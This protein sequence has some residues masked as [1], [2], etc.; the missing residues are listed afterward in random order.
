MTE[1]EYAKEII[2]AIGGILTMFEEYHIFVPEAPRASHNDHTDLLVILTKSK[3][4]FNIE[5][6]RGKIKE[7]RIQVERT[8]R[9]TG[10]RTYG[11][12]PEL[13][14]PREHLYNFDYEIDIDKFV[15]NITCYGRHGQVDV[16]PWYQSAISRLYW[17]GYQDR[18]CQSN[19]FPAVLES[20]GA[21]NADRLSLYQLFRKAC[22]QI[23]AE[24]RMIVGFDIIYPVLGYG[25]YTESVAKKHYRDAVKIFKER[26]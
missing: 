9:K 23:F 1:N 26:K 8:E 24:Q 13:K 18:W 19:F 4:M 22:L 15:N 20:V 14:A 6:K 7:H 10:I 17:F 11:L 12:N 3:Q 21:K 2:P 5:F 16:T 25:A